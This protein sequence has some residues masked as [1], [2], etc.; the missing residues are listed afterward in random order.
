MSDD[1][2]ISDKFHEVLKHEGVVS[3]MTSGIEAHL[4]NSWNSYIVVTDDERLL[5]PAY[6]YKKTGKNLDVNN[7]ITISVGSKNVLGYKDYPGTGFIV[8]GT[9]GFIDSGAEFDMMKEKFSFLNRVLEVTVNTAK[10]ML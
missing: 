6:A 5:L 4:V 9:A 10:Q 3:I 2:K 8:K 1:K 7:Q